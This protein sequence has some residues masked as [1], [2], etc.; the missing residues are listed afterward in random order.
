MGRARF[1]FYTGFIINR[2]AMGRAR[3]L[4]YTGFINRAAMGRARFLLYTGFIIIIIFFFL[5]ARP[6]AERGSCFARDLLLFFFCIFFVGDQTQT[7]T[8]PNRHRDW[9]TQPMMFIRQKLL[10]HQCTENVADIVFFIGNKVYFLLVLSKRWIE[11]ECWIRCK[12]VLHQP[13]NALMLQVSLSLRD[14]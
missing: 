11:S 5:T 1:L 7:S 9:I 8:R 4:L 12:K 3:F 2:A 14:K 10:K 13:W 6:W